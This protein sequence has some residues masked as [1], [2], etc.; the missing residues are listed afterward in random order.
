MCEKATG[1]NLKLTHTHRSDNRSG[2]EQTHSCSRWR[3]MESEVFRL[4][5][6]FDSRSENIIY[7]H[8]NG[9]GSINSAVVTVTGLWLLLCVFVFDVRIVSESQIGVRVMQDSVCFS[10]VKL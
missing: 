8:I 7:N 3:L 2:M 10:L 6:K 4:G 9:S 5:D 1:D